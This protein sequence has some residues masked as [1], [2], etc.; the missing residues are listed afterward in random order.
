[1][2]GTFIAAILLS[3]APADVDAAFA[4]LATLPADQQLGMAYLSL[5]DVPEDRQADLEAAAKVVVCSLSH[6]SHLPSQLP[7]RL[8]TAPVLRL[9]L[10]S[11]GWA[12]GYPA[13]VTKH[14][15]YRPEITKQGR[16]PLVISALWFVSQVTDPVETPGAQDVLLYGKEQK[17]LNDVLA[18]WKAGNDQ[19]LF[20]GYL[21]GKSGVS[22]QRART[23]EN[24]PSGNRGY[25]WG[26][27]DFEKL[28]AGSDPL[29]NLK[30][31]STRFDATEWVIGIPKAESGRFGMLNA[32][33]LADANGNI[34]AKAPASIV[35]DHGQLR[36]VEIRNWISC[37][38]C[39]PLGLVDPTVDEYRQYLTAGATISAYDKAT[40]EAI[41]GYLEAD[42]AG[43]LKR[44][45][46]L[47]AAGIEMVCGLTPE[48][49]AKAFVAA[50]KAYDADVT[51]EQAAREVG[52]TVEDL[53]LAIAWQSAKGVN[54]G[55]RLAQ[56][57][58]GVAIPRNRFEELGY[59]AATYVTA[60]R[61]SRK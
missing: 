2:T 57:P 37:I 41:E 30:P 13:V 49:F 39:H 14:Y 1:M 22:L 59:T 33:V 4:D 8:K 42:I 21:E 29:E 12:K 3:V 28:D 18:F 20:F 31:G 5:S 44:D 45:R 15:P 9:D 25:V 47:Y 23:I 61:E 52:C 53:K 16:Y 43:Q 7:V 6:K 35:A 58:D 55:A 46:E 60:W 32:Y 11:L 27:K 48:A 56:L 38:N 36:G 40:K 34:Q 17:S 24:R 10:Y 54:V 26:T 19:Q 50:V 51:L